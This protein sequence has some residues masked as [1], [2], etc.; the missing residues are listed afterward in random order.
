MALVPINA[1]YGIAV[2]GL[3]ANPLSGFTLATPFTCSINIAGGY[4][5]AA[6]TTDYN[7]IWWFGDGTYSTEYSP[8]HIYNWPGVYEVKLGIF[9]NNTNVVPVTFSTTVTASNFVHN[10]LTWNYA[11]WPDLSTDL[12]NISG[13]CFHGY[14][15]CKS[16]TAV[17]G[18]LPITFNYN[19]SILDNSALN[20]TLYSQNS[21]SQPYTQIPSSQL[22]NLR[23]SWRFT[24]VSA[25]SLDTDH[26]IDN[27]K[28]V[29]STE[30]RILSSGML[31]PNGVLVGLSGTASFYYI[32]DI[33]SMV[34]HSNSV[35]ANPTTLWVTLDTTNVNNAQGTDYISVPSYSNSLV[36]LSSYYYVQSFKPDHIN[37]TIN[38]HIPFNNIYWPSVESRFVTTINSATTNGT[39]AFLSNARLLNYP[40]DIGN[41][42]GNTFQVSLSSNKTFPLSGVSFNLST[43]PVTSNSL[44]Y[45]LTRHDNLGRDTGGYYLG[46]FTPYITGAA[47]LKTTNTFTPPYSGF[48]YVD[49]LA[50]SLSAGYNPTLI[51]LPVTPT[52]KYITS[53]TLNSLGSYGMVGQ[54]STFNLVNF[55]NTY[56]TRKFNGGFDMGNQLRTYSLQPTINQNTNLF[57][58]YLSS[59]VG[60]S[61][62]NDDTLGGVIYEKIAN[63]VQNVSDP[64]TANLYRFYSLADSLGIT[65]DN[66]N[67]DI[68][69][70]LSRVVD[71]YSTQQSTIWGARSQFARN[72]SLSAGHVNLNNSLTEYNLRTAI[73]TAGQL[74]VINDL[75]NSQYYELLEVPKITSYSSITARN[76][77]HLFGGYSN[78][79]YP[80][81]AYPLSS[82]FGWGVKTPVSQNYRFFVYNDVIDGQQVEGLVNWDDSITTLSE[83]S[84]ASHT[85]WV[86]D[87][88]ILE[89]IF[90]YYIHKGLGLTD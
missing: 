73:V 65:L 31:D 38:G 28:P 1:I 63:F 10:K 18:P 47:I 39:G 56:F 80:L 25:S 79:H 74:I 19:T 21:L 22:S 29:S 44:Q 61:A 5:Q 46:T 26:A 64:S 6:I 70:A 51:P 57:E 7:L 4:T 48:A 17:T 12:A 59:I 53:S 42:L 62:T 14:Q 60:I 24:T 68:P 33:P 50:P 71:L 30:I 8:S 32:D 37:I 58:N 49:D 3:A 34:V 69:P 43:N 27:I 16:G 75:F 83:L 52:I 88:G 55:N 82:F 77:Q 85:E 54:S 67:Y 9:N 13:R 81:T 86:K 11:Q 41:N 72:F 84:G 66:Y 89:T 23:P 2:S 20:F 76:L 35:S 45:T 36:S 78:A 90:N 87:G 40:L 15:S